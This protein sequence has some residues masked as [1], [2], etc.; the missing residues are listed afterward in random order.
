MPQQRTIQHYAQDGTLIGESTYEVPDEIVRREQAESGLR[1]I[2][3][4]LKTA[5]TESQADQ[6]ALQAL[7]DANQSG[8]TANQVRQQ[9]K[10]TQQLL[11]A[12]QNRE[13]RGNRL[14]RHLLLLLDFDADDGQE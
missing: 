14:F 8:L 13:Q 10:D 6:A 7:I 11:K 2:R 9:L 5:I 4:L 3:P 12:L 1:G